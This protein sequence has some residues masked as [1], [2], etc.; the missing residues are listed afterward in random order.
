MALSISSTDTTPNTTAV[1][2]WQQR[3]QELKQLAAAL[4]SGDIDAAQAAYASLNA[5]SNGQGSSPRAQVGQAVQNGDLA[6]AQQAF[7]ALSKGHSHRHH[8]HSA[9]SSE[10]PTGQTPTSGT[11]INTS[12]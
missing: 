1:T 4:Q 9:P 12:A 2:N 8:H 5:P 3:Q 6:G 10:A 7:Q 11:I